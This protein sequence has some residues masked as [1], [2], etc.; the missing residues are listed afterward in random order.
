MPAITTSH[1]VSESD[2]MAALC[3]I[4]EADG[5]TCQI[6]GRILEIQEA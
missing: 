1:G 2:S 6:E 4:I 5:G 3:D